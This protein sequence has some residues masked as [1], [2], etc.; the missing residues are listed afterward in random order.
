MDKKERG[1]RE[2]T[3]LSYPRKEKIAEKV[4]GLSIPRSSEE[5]NKSSF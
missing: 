4:D 3:C 5:L 1:A 2:R